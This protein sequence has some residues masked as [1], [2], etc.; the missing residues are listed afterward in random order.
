MICSN[1]Y[2]G[3]TNNEDEVVARGSSGCESD[4]YN[5]TVLIAELYSSTTKLQLIINVCYFTLYSYSV[6]WFYQRLSIQ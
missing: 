1:G 2:C 5:M 3:K 6:F 4:Y